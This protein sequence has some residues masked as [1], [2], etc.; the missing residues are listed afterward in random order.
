MGTATKGAPQNRKARINLSARYVFSL[1]WMN[2]RH[3]VYS[4]NTVSNDN[5]LR[6]CLLVR[7][8]GASSI[9]S[10]IFNVAYAVKTGTLHRQRYFGQISR[11]SSRMRRPYNQPHLF[12]EPYILSK[13]C[14]N[15]FGNA[16]M[17]RCR[18][19]GDNMYGA[20][21]FSR[22]DFGGEILFV[23]TENFLESAVA[24]AGS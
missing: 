22:R 19:C 6:R 16:P 13:L 2:N 5:K 1:L 4:E 12:G 15:D 9:G 11:T 21:N 8:N 10:I 24:G 14:E 7:T 17:R 3:T 23:S 18:M 20:T